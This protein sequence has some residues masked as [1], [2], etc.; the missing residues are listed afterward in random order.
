MRERGSHVVSPLAL[1]LG[2]VALAG[3][4]GGATATQAQK[5]WLYHG[6][7]GITVTLEV[8]DASLY[9]QLLPEAFAMPER[10]VAAVAMASYY[11][12]VAP[13]VPYREGYVLLACSY[14]GRSGWY[15][16]TMPV[17]DQVANDGG[18]AMGFPKYVADRIDLAE[19]GGTWSGQVVRGG[20]TAM[21]MTFTPLPTAQLVAGTGDAP[22]PLFNLLPPGTGPAVTEVRVAI[23]GQRQVQAL[24]GTAT[25]AAGAGE[26]WAGLLVGATALSA[27]YERISG[28]YTLELVQ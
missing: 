2:V 9:R 20:V 28:S 24:A 25:V 15:T 14:Q 19:S 16:V 8:A 11:D 12:V 26:S 3:C 23:D 22:L 13:L 10:L 7:E 1:L 21:Q 17:D 6:Q 27:Q 18:R 5:T 4:S